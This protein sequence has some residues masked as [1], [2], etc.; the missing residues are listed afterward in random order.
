M[1]GRAF[2]YSKG[3]REEQAALIRWQVQ[4]TEW[5]RMIAS[6]TEGEHIPLENASHQ[7][8]FEYPDKVSMAVSVIL[9]EDK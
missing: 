3:R 8:L 4:G 5:S 6:N 1:Y 2:R 7:V 9:K